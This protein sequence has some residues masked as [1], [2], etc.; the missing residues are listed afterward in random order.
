VQKT[1]KGGK[2]TEMKEA[3]GDGIELGQGENRKGLATW[4]AEPAKPS[5][6]CSGVSGAS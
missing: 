5:L 1:G 6:I 3:M 2:R 4:A